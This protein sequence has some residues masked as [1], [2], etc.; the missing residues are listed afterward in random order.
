M[1]GFAYVVKEDPKADDILYVGTEFGL[2]VS[3]DIGGELGRFSPNNFPHVAV[4]D[5]AFQ[6][7]DDDLVIATH[8]RGIWIADDMSPLRACILRP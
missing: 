5:L 3:V 6:I 8:G 4:R 1:R 7:R 2:F